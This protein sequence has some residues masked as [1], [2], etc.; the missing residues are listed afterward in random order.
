MQV[1]DQV[2]IKD[3]LEQ[4]LT[5]NGMERVQSQVSMF[6]QTD[7]RNGLKIRAESY[8]KY[9]VFLNHEVFWGI[10]SYTLIYQL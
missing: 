5:L 8:L 6:S 10:Y 7:E 2:Y 9:R 4:V 1:S 3:R